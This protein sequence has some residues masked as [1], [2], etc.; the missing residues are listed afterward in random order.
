MLEARGRLYLHPPVTRPAAW[1][2]P[3]AAAGVWD[4]TG[5]LLG[6]LLLLQVL[7]RF[8]GSY[9]ASVTYPNSL[10]GARL[11]ESHTL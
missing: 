3:G 4:S 7:S 8:P 2:P 10:Q 11:K 9:L 1:E 6:G 5:M